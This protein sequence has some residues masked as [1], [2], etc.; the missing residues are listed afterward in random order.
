MNKKGKKLVIFNSIILLLVCTYTIG[1]HYQNVKKLNESIPEV[2]L[3]EIVN[4]EK[5]MAIM[6]SSDG[7]NYQEYNSD[8]WP[9][10]SYKFKE[11]KCIDNSGDEVKEAVTYEEG[12]IT[13]TTNK[14]VYCTVYFDYKGTINILRENDQNKVLS[15]EEV[16]GMYRYQGL[17]KQYENDDVNNPDNLPVVDNNYICFG[18]DD[19]NECISDNDKYLYRI[20][21]ITKKE[22][23]YLIKQSTLNDNGYHYFTRN[24][25]Y[26][27]DSGT[28]TDCPN[29]K[30][31]EWPNTL[32]F[33]RLNGI[34]N[35]TKNGEG[36]AENGG[37]TDI[38]ID[39]RNSAE[40][41]W[42]RI[43]ENHDY[44]YGDIYWGKSYLIDD[45]KIYGVN[46][47]GLTLYQIETGVLPTAHFAYENGAGISNKIRWDKSVNAKIGLI[48]MS[49]YLL[50]YSNNKL[51][52]GE[53][54]KSW[55]HYGK[56]GLGTPEGTIARF[57]VNYNNEYNS[58]INT[59]WN[60][61]PLNWNSPISGNWDRDGLLI[62]PTFYLSNSLR[63]IGEGTK[64][65]PFIINF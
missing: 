51:A 22:Q 41:E 13:L 16:A 24:D 57:S 53:E 20:I 4:K 12:K 21:G 48:Y 52:D 26:T 7:S 36:N 14:T 8:T 44:M 64:D 54:K 65:N 39:N 15:S 30:C 45:E 9:S 23:L 6:I 49:D 46:N 55:I 25:T 35:G 33:K 19:K 18:T 62:R 50:S 27:I 3:K 32:L 43:I 42:Y 31:P 28:N 63:I 5:T 29:K 56:D 11:A 1:M 61:Y 2:K 17:D 10:N 60:I 59:Y 38:F 37:D 47:D 34:S 58:W 40:S